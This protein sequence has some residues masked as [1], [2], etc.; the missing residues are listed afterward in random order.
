MQLTLVEEYDALPEDKKGSAE[1][2]AAMR[3]MLMEADESNSDCITGH[4]RR[5]I[6]KFASG[7]SPINMT[8]WHLQEAVLTEDRMNDSSKSIIASNERLIEFLVRKL[9]NHEE[10]SEEQEKS[11]SGYV[12]RMHTEINID[13]EI[14]Q[15][16]HAKLLFKSTALA[17]DDN[18]LNGAV[19]ETLASSLGRFIAI[20]CGGHQEHMSDFLEG[21]IH[22][23][24]NE[25]ARTQKVG[26][27]FVKFDKK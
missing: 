27:L 26:K 6:R 17:R 18:N 25:A 5:I 22:Y 16:E 10:L 20:M 14:F 21:A 15:N 3:V 8:I 9:I 23:A 19:V 12:N 13:A 7:A 2:V 1:D 24:E 4:M 11:F